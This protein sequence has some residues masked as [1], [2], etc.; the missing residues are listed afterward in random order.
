M[1]AAERM[2]IVDDGMTGY[3]QLDCTRRRSWDCRKT[4]AEKVGQRVINLTLGS[5][6][7]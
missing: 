6:K 2:A 5:R 3:R 4:R 7:L 1:V